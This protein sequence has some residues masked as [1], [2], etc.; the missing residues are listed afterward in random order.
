MWE[1]RT[2]TWYCM[3]LGWCAG[4]ISDPQL[5][6]WFFSLNW[7]PNYDKQQMA[8]IPENKYSKDYVTEPKIS[9]KDSIAR[10]VTS[11]KDDYNFIL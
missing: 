3:M 10:W 9:S 7:I 5:P 2:E 1:T 11:E 6:A 8:A 4:I